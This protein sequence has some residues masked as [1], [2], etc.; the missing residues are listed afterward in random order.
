M[1][2]LPD[3]TEALQNALYCLSMLVILG[4]FCVPMM[5]P[6]RTTTFAQRMAAAFWWQL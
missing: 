4:A 5:Y 1:I 6:E 2:L 3:E